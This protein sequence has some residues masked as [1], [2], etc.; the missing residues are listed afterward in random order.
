MSKILK[1]DGR[2]RG[3]RGIVSVETREPG[4]AERPRVIWRPRDSIL[5]GRGS[6]RAGRKR[7]SSEARPLGIV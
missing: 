3:L 7:G 5:A 4:G 1:I 2:I 6:V